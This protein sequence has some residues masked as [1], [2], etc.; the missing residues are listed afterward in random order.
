M[1]FLRISLLLSFVFAS[2]CGFIGP[3]QVIPTV[4]TMYNPKKVGE[5][6]TEASLIEGK[7][8][9]SYLINALGLPDRSG[10]TYTYSYVTYSYTSRPAH[11]KAKIRVVRRDGTD[12]YIVVGNGE[13]YTNV[14]VYFDAREIITNISIS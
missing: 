1:K 8:Q 3:Q 12:I 11:I 9:K 6:Y 7:T 13:K 14:T 4:L 5:Y 2:A 10:R